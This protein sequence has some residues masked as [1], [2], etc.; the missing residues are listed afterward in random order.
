MSSELGIRNKK[1][2]QSGVPGGVLLVFWTEEIED[3]L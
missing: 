3:F 2:V 1:A